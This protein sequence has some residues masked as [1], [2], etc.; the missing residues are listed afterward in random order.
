[1]PET[2]RFARVLVAAD[3]RMKRI[4][5]GL[6]PAPIQGLPSF[7]QLM[8]GGS[9]GSRNMLPRWWLAPDYQPVLRDPDG[10]AWELRGANVKAMAENAFFN[11]SGV[12]EKT[13]PADAVSQRWAD[14]MTRRYEDLAKA[15]PV[16]GE[17]RNC[18]D[19]AI[20]AAVVARENLIAK[21][22]CSLPLLT[23]SAALETMKLPAPKQIESKAVL[24]RKAKWTIAAGGVEINPWDIVQ[25]AEPSP[26]LG[27]VRSKAASSQDTAWWWD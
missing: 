8:K 14:T 12:R 27:Q 23:D 7:L 18:M 20:V 11:A 16:F 26:Q 15:E 4:S 10:L 19:L 1:V 5:M 24:V 22:G 25:K 9:A 6:E 21:A 17:L 13:A 3:Y 2:S